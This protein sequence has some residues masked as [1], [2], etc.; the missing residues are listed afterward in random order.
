[1]KHIA[2]IGLIVGLSGCDRQ[3]YNTAPDKGKCWRECA[4][5]ASASSRPNDSFAFCVQTACNYQL[6]ACPK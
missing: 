3:C 2:L 4:Q 6:V 5:T 1:M